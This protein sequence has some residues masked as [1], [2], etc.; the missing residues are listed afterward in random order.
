VRG[1]TGADVGLATTGVA[2]PDP[3]DGNAPGLVFVAVTT[4]GGSW[5][6]RLDLDGDRAAVRAGAV[7]GVLSLA[8]DVLAGPSAAHGD[9]GV[10]TV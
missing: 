1:A 2:G 7:D 5:V 6:R 10:A 9:P 8:L 3:Q 4:P